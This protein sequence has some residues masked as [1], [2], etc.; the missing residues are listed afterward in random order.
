[1]KKQWKSILIV[2]SAGMLIML[3]INGLINVCSSKSNQ[4]I[5][6]QQEYKNISFNQIKRQK[7][8]IYE[9]Q[10]K[11]EETQENI[12]EEGVGCYI[13]NHMQIP[14]NFT[15]KILLYE[16]IEYGVRKYNEENNQTT[17]YS[18]DMEEDMLLFDIE[19]CMADKDREP[20]K[21]DLAKEIIPELAN[22][23][24]NFRLSNQNDT[25]YMSIDTYNMKIYVY[26][27]IVQ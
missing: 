11:Q 3:M 24:Y 25:I 9:N 12:E 8:G 14:I 5:E 15:K 16:Y 22:N 13:S 26:D 1:M 23:I 10:E 21:T 19:F 2:F 20:Y 7:E 18:C 6:R 17:I 27:T 4:N